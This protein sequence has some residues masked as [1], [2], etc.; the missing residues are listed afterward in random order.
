MKKNFI[1]IASAAIIALFLFNNVKSKKEDMQKKETINITVTSSSFSKGQPLSPKYAYTNCNGE[2]KSPQISWQKID[3]AKSY[4]VICD[5]PDAPSAKAPRPNPWVH[6]VVYDL[7]AASTELGESASIS[8]LGGKEGKNDFGNYRY[9]GPCPPA[10]SGTHRYFFKVIATDI[11]SLKL[12]A[13][14]TKEEVLDAARD[15]LIGQ[16]EIMGTY[17]IS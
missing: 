6:W 1:I 3:G 17:E 9:D 7:P 10:G 15:H 13:G 12:S 4:I 16:G 11:D 2:N 5:D 8:E 14:A